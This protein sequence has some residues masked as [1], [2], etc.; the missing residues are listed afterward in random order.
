MDWN[1]TYILA[2]LYGN[3]AII[4]LFLSLFISNKYKNLKNLF[5]ILIILLISFT[6]SI[7]DENV[8]LDTS[9]Y[10]KLFL[11]DDFSAFYYAGVYDIGY[12]LF[13]K[14]VRLYTDNYHIFLFFITLIHLILIY[15]LYK[16]LDSKL[17]NVP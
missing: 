11:K 1:E 10:V 12:I 9:V 15:F 17:G 3:I 4:F 5:I 16:S 7:R 6:I 2:A 13:N 14:F 8:A